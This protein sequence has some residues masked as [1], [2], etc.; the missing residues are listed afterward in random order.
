MNTHIEALVEQLVQLGDRLRPLEHDLWRSSLPS[1][2]QPLSKSSRIV[3]LSLSPAQSAELRMRITQIR[4]AILDV[5]TE[6]QTIQLGGPDAW[7]EEERAMLKTQMRGAWQDE[8]AVPDFVCEG[9]SPS[10][11]TLQELLEFDWDRKANYSGLITWEKYKKRI[12]ANVIGTPDYYIENI[13]GT[14]VLVIDEKQAIEC[15]ETEKRLLA[16]GKICG[17]DLY[18]RVRWEE[19]YRES[20]GE[21]HSVFMTWL[22]KIDIPENVRIVFYFY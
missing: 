6:L 21:F 12:A 20:V 8:K 19:T 13:Y 10:W 5:I 3:P 9:F 4:L 1:D 17:S 2:Y 18:V 22:Q 15:Y 16:G 14:N 11:L 7:V